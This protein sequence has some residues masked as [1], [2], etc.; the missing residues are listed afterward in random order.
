MD[1][2]TEIHN[3]QMDRILFG[4]QI[5]RGE[6]PPIPDRNATTISEYGPE[7]CLAIKIAVS[8]NDEVSLGFGESAHQG[9]PM[10][11]RSLA[12]IFSLAEGMSEMINR[13]NSKILDGVFDV[14]ESL[15]DSTYK[16]L[17][18]SC[19]ELREMNE[20]RQVIVY[21]ISHAC[22]VQGVRLTMQQKLLKEQAKELEVCRENLLQALEEN[23]RYKHL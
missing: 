11:Y 16:D 12:Q 7:N 6:F 9:G 17:S 8:E 20:A 13:E 10:E 19:G 3:Q 2:L 1:N 4:E 23:D 15:K 18:E 5:F 21:S 22:R 14:R